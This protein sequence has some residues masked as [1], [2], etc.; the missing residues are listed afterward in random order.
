MN[1]LFFLGRNNSSARATTKINDAAYKTAQ[2]DM[3]LIKNY[4]NI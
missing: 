1:A 3:K 2:I 4:D